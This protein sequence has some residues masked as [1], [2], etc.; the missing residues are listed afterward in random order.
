MKRLLLTLAM[1]AAAHAAA[2]TSI[3]PGLWELNNKVRTG[4]AQTDQA[5]SAALSQLAALPPAQRAQME[6]MMAQNGIS[7]PKAG[8]DGGLTL[9]ACVTPEMAARKE[10]PLNQQ[11]KCTSTQQ[12][13]AGG[14]NVSFTCTNP[15]SS[16]TGQIR[17]NGDQAYTMTM[18]VINNSGAGP[19]N[20]TVESTGRWLGDTCPARPK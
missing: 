19:Q 17:F 4:N 18:N 5:V 15:A 2:Q 1:A 10:L 12:P 20:A 3:K 6:A 8:G 7:M 9:T 11:G 14:M 16:G 13:V